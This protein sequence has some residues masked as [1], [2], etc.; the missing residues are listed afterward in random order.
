MRAALVLLTT[1]VLL[2]G[3]A[4]PDNTQAEIQAQYDRY[5]EAYVENDVEAMLAIL[6]D[7]FIL[8]DGQG[9]RHTRKEYEAEL[10]ERRESGQKASSYRV[11]IDSVVR[12][13]DA[14]SVITREIST[15][16]SEPTAVHQYRDVWVQVDGVWKLKSTT[17]VEHADPE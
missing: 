1:A 14:A 13:G 9:V 12:E 10:K 5:A 17:T 6:A 7:D 3:C 4:K 16:I 15:S 8:T 11:E 2:A